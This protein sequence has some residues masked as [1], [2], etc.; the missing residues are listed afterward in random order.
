MAEQWLS[1]VEYARSYSVSDMTVRR[2]IKTGKLHAV[3][4][5]GKYY[6]PVAV[7]NAGV[8]RNS[9][10]EQSVSQAKQQ[11]DASPRRAD[12]SV[13]KSHPQAQM[14]FTPPSVASDAG[15]RGAQN[16]STMFNGELA[17]ERLHA[18]ENFASKILAPDTPI[19]PSLRTS[20][21]QRG[22]SLVDSRALLAFCDGSLRSSN[23]AEKRVEDLFRSRVESLSIQLKARDQ[24][25]NHL[26]QQI[27]DLQLLV[28]IL[29]KKKA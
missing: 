12:V 17:A 6:I 28:Q 22:S 7:E 1:I 14:T 16:F 8:A 23:A 15:Q 19:P 4:K 2:R 3:L 21:D 20:L 29:E 26:R 5:E 11:R 10:R 9:G 18:E 27:E 25:V 24:E 13:V